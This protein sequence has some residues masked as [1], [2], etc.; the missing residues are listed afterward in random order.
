MSDSLMKLSALACADTPGER[1]P[2][3][4]SVKINFKILGGLFT[5]SNV[6]LAHDMSGEISK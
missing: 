2:L 5:F 6:S 3:S 1:A 4:G